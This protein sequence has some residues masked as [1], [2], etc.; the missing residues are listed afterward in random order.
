MNSKSDYERN[1]GAYT[2]YGV[3][4]AGMPKGI[5][6]SMPGREVHSGVGYGGLYE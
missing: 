5:A 3:G 2:H 4:Y 6:H 1:V